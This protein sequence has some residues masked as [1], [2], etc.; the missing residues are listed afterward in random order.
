MC[1]SFGHCTMDPECLVPHNMLS[2]RLMNLG[3]LGKGLG[4]AS[5]RLFAWIMLITVGAVHI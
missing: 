4:K 1:A 5:L 3:L 2:V